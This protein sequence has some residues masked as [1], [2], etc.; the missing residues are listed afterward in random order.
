MFLEGFHFHNK[1][2]KGSHGKY[3]NVHE[4]EEIRCKDEERKKKHRVKTGNIICIGISGQVKWRL[5]LFAFV[6]YNIAPYF[7]KD[8]TVLSTCDGKLRN[9]P[10]GINMLNGLLRYGTARFGLI[11]VS[12]FF[13]FF[14]K[15]KQ[16]ASWVGFWWDRYVWALYSVRLHFTN[17]WSRF[18][19]CFVVNLKRF[20]RQWFMRELCECCGRF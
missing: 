13:F 15:M 3:I 12:A 6:M 1:R 19:A 9:A 5:W 11:C 2:A 10:E 17:L 16:L 14:V 20:S 4:C 8:T 18:Y 7:G